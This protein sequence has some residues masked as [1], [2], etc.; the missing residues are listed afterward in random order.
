MRQDHQVVDEPRPGHGGEPSADVGAQQ[1]VG[2]GLALDLVADAPQ[3]RAAGELREARQLVGHV[4][5]GQV[6]PADHSPDQLT[7]RR[8]GEELRRLLGDGDRL[9]EHGPVDPGRPCLRFEVRDSEVPP[10]GLEFRAGD[11]VLVAD[12]QVPDV[13]VGVDRH[14][15][16][17]TTGRPASAPAPE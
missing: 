11:P 2:V 7:L 10:Q 12:G 13:V 14:G 9:H 5:P 3:I 16:S 8:E 15:S 4:R 17:H 1:P 6:G